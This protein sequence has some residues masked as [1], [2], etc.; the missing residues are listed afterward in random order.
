MLSKEGFRNRTHR[1]I[2]IGGLRRTQKQT[3]VAALSL[4]VVAATVE[5]IVSLCT[6][7]L[8]YIVR[9]ARVAGCMLLAGAK[10]LTRCSRKLG[11]WCL[12]C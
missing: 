11:T 7:V 5:L 6:R 8:P 10:E 4:T 1:L 2:L 9:V 3:S 12:R